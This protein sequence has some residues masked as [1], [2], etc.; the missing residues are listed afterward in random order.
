MK[1]QNDL[2]LRETI[3]IEKKTRTDLKTQEI[4]RTRLEE[5]AKT[6]EIEE[7]KVKSTESL[8][9]EIRV[10][11]ELQ[12]ALL[13]NQPILNVLD[14]QDRKLDALLEL[15]RIIIPRLLKEGAGDEEVHRL[16]EILKSFGKPGDYIL[17]TH[18]KG[19]LL[20]SGG[21]LNIAENK[22]NIKTQ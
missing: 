11:V 4:E 10:V 2:R 13:E 5:E 3:A 14:A 17:G 9:N 15:Q 19:D 12:R 18:F 7:R 6:R 21:D 20:T 16:T 22:S 1:R 8:I